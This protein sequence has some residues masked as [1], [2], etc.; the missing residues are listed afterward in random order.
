[1]LRRAWLALIIS[2]AAL[3]APG[4]DTGRRWWSYVQY[5]ADDKLE[6]RL[7]GSEGHHKAAEFVAAEF[8][9]SGLDPAGTNG[10]VQPVKFHS[11]VIKEDQSSLALVR[12]GKTEPLKLGEDAIFSFRIEPAK[13]IEAPLAFVGYGLKVPEFKYDDLA[14]LDL[15]GKVVVYFYGG[16]ANIPGALRSHY[17]A[18]G[19]RWKVL[20]QA[21]AIGTIAIQNPKHMDIPWDRV[22]LSRFQPSMSLADPLLDETRGQKFSATVNPARAEKL[23]ASS[24]HSF[25]ELLKLADDGKKLPTFALPAMIKAKVSFEPKEF[26]SQNV[27]GVLPG[28][29]PNLKNEY[30][31][32]SAHLDHLGI[33]EPINGDRIYN[34]AMDNASGVATILDV[35]ASLHDS[36]KKTRRSL[37]FLALTGEEKGLLGSRY[38]VTHPTVK[39]EALVADVNV[40]MF[41]PLFPL[42]V[43]TVLGLNDS[44]LGP[45]LRSIAEKEGI[46][47]QG[48]LEPDRNLFIRSDQYNFIRAG[49]PSIYFKVG[50]ES[51]SPEAATV[52]K[53]LTERYHAPSDDTKQPV[54]LAAAAEYDKVVLL[55]AESIADRVERPQWDGDSFF[56]RY[57]Q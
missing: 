9:R 34:G 56:R 22:A 5:L 8:K 47:V 30:V 39:R 41:L 6:G 1:M 45:L 11:R 37:L 20:K 4:P 50:Y 25:D 52:K 29:D 36:G 17:Q 48:D 35:A 28:S 40:D 24:G 33:G 15:R 31:V 54:D 16:P 51:G 13:S 32:L 19:E 2:G 55:L 7:T 44:D 18:L 49:I 26:E 12:E 27:V 42:K 53:W 57:A 3:A 46:K 10:Y 43:L 14:G 21:G 23:F 38:F